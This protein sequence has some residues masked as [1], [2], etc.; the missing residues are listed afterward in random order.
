MLTLPESKR[1]AV[2]VQNTAVGPDAS[3]RRGELEEA[4]RDWKNEAEF[5]CVSSTVANSTSH[6]KEKT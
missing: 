2:Y 4:T 3:G 1:E 5:S 6:M